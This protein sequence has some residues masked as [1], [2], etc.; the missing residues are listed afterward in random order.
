MSLSLFEF[1][2]LVFQEPFTWIAAFIGGAVSMAMFFS[3]LI[4]VLTGE[5]NL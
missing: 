5:R 2:W 3:L 1:L 4:S